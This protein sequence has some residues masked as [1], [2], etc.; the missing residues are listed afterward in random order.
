[1]AFKGILKELE[2]VLLKIERLERKDMIKK[3][4]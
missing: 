4:S 2:L 1:M 3:I